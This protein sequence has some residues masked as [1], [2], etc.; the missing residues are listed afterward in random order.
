M[1]SDISVHWMGWSDVYGKHY[2]LLKP[3][4]ST[5]RESPY[6]C[7]FNSCVCQFKENVFPACCMNFNIKNGKSCWCIN[8]AIL[9]VLLLGCLVFLFYVLILM[10]APF[11]EY[12]CLQTAFIVE[13]FAVISVLSSFR[14]NGWNT[15]RRLKRKRQR[16]TKLEEKQRLPRGLL[17]P[18]LPRLQIVSYW[19]QP[20]KWSISWSFHFFSVSPW[21]NSCQ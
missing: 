20:L 15:W 21:Q 16:R 19:T 1:P 8:P 13:R 10:W 18:V 7:H 6:S 17:S 4:I 14:D 5:L 11:K 2:G 9:R 12:F 3:Q